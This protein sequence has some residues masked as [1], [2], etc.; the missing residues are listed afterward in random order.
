ME[1]ETSPG[2][3]QTP[4]A[5]QCRATV[6][7]DRASKCRSVLVDKQEWPGLDGRGLSIAT[8]QT[9]LRK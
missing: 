3:P 6:G 4:R 2:P 9:A 8:V 1:P 5:A 7:K